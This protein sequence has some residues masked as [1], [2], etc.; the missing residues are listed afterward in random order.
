MALPLLSVCW[1]RATVNA[2]DKILR[3]DEPVSIRIP[4]I[5]W[6]WVVLPGAQTVTLVKAPST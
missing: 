5:V 3:P 6:H 2:E 1:G 4:S